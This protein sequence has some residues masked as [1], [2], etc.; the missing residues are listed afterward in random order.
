LA[1]FVALGVRLEGDAPKNGELTADCSLT[2][3][4]QHTCRF[5]SRIYYQ[6]AMWKHWSIPH[7]FWPGRS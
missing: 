6:R 4:L 5:W 2:T 1:S 3:M 7:T